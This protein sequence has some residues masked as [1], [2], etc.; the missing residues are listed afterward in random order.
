MDYPINAVIVGNGDVA[1]KGK[2]NKKGKENY[3]GP[4]DTLFW[5]FRDSPE[6]HSLQVSRLLPSLELIPTIM[7]D[8]T[9]NNHGIVMLQLESCAGFMNHCR[10]IVYSLA[11]RPA[12]FKL[13]LFFQPAAFEASTRNS[14]TTVPYLIGETHVYALAWK[15][16]KAKYMLEAWNFRTQFREYQTDDLSPDLCSGFGSGSGSDDNAYAWKGN[17]PSQEGFS[18]GCEKAALF[19]RLNNESEDCFVLVEDLFEPS[20]HGSLQACL[21]EREGPV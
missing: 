10:T 19:W 5:R 6:V 21:V 18:S 8:C 2:W 9:G 1:W 14:K 15:P 17:A 3:Q 4:F 16:N 7:Y 12:L 13:D 11:E 20:L